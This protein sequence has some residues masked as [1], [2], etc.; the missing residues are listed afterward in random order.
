MDSVPLPLRG[1]NARVDFVQRLVH[2]ATRCEPTVGPAGP[3]GGIWGKQTES[4]VKQFQT[5]NSLKSNQAAG[6]QP[7]QGHRAGPD[8]I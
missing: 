4:A 1:A 8:G 3:T 5:D 6:K 2:T 7:F